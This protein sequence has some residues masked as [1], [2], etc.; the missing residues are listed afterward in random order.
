M[1]LYHMA[2]G[3]RSGEELFDGSEDERC[4]TGV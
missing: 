4:V 1:L 3:G 2:G